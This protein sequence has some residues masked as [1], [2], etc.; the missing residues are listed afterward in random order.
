MSDEEDYYDEGYDGEWLFWD[1]GD[2][3]IVDDLANGTIHSPVYLTDQALYA[4]LE[5]DSDWDYYTDEYYDDDPS[6][7]NRQEGTS[8]NSNSKT[9]GTKRKRFSVDQDGRPPKGVKG[10]YPDI[11]SF[12]G[13]V[14]RTPSHSLRREELYE[15]GMGETVSLLRNWRELF[16]YPEPKS[17]SIHA[18][19]STTH[20]PG[21]PK[22][23]NH[24][25]DQISSLK[26]E[27]YDSAP[28]LC[29]DE[30][31]EDDA[32]TG[33][34]PY[35]LIGRSA[36]TPPPLHFNDAAHEDLESASGIS[37]EPCKHT[38]Q[39][40]RTSHKPSSRL[41]QMTAVE[42]IT[43]PSSAD[44]EASRSPP[45]DVTS[46][47]RKTTNGS[48]D[49]PDPQPRQ[50]IQVLVGPPKRPE[51]SY[52]FLAD[53]SVSSEKQLPRHYGKKRKASPSDLAEQEEGKAARKRGRPAKMGEA[54]SQKAPAA[55]VSRSSTSVENKRCLRE[56]KK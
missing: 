14:W 5:S 44:T 36:Y 17:P 31:V 4:A 27:I 37:S 46:E 32:E 8:M 22:T 7:V 40:K 41:K 45:P 3:D 33:E 30:C 26:P 13:V 12:R 53:D 50:G 9:P 10:L 16:T 35:S 23:N 42:D 49:S 52:H 29:E 55:K 54:A 39:S 2:A 51:S 20:M 38:F 24:L 34:S 48:A 18:N 21:L 19:H 47:R 56:R 1:E 11:N 15:P 6:I 25:H 28:S 43:P